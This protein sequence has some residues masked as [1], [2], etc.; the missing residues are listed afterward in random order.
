MG[1]IEYHTCHFK[2]M[3]MRA[4]LINTDHDNLGKRLFS[5]SSFFFKR[6]PVENRN[7]SLSKDVSL[8]VKRKT[9]VSVFEFV[10]QTKV[11]GRK[12]NL[13]REEKTEIQ[14]SSSLFE[15]LYSSHHF[16]VIIVN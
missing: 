11:K 13:E 15:T 7:L 10:L 4:V 6:K 3:E 12:R 2:P 8:D 1:L 5:L 9:A 14:S 16:M